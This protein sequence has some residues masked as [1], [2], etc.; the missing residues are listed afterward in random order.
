MPQIDLGSVVGPQ[1]PQGNTGPQGQQGVQGIVGPNQ[2]TAATSTT[3]GAAAAP[4][5][6]TGNGSKVGYKAIDSEP[7]ANSQNLISSQAV[8]NA[9]NSK[10]NYMLFS[11][12]NGQK[13][14]IT[15]GGGNYL[16]VFGLFILTAGAAISMDACYVISGLGNRSNFHVVNTLFS[17]SGISLVDNGETIVISNL[18]GTYTMQIGL[19][20][21]IDSNGQLSFAVS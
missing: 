13:L 2:V 5:V 14:T 7:T 12:P 1:G 11:V 3:L 4:V 10:A 19:L 16:E 21:L 15:I 18:H 17:S 6:L 9:L 8:A 20:V